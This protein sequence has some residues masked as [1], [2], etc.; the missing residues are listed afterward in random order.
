MTGVSIPFIAQ[1]CQPFA[2]PYKEFLGK[3]SI[4]LLCILVGNGLVF[5]REWEMKFIFFLDTI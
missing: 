2:L 3:D 1:C 5:P 4:R